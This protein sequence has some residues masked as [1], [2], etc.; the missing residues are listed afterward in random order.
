MPRVGF[1]HEKSDIKI[2]ILYILKRLPSTVDENDL[3]AL[4][5]CD[6]GIDYFDYI[7]CIE[8]LVKSE[9]IEK[10]YFGVVISPKGAKYIEYIETSLPI[11][12][13]NK[14]DVEIVP[15]A[16]KL[17]RMSLLSTKH[18]LTKD[19]VITTLSM[20]DGAGEL[21]SLNIAVPSEEKALQIEKKFRKDAEAIYYKILEVLMGENIE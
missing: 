3:W 13:R 16:K 4:V 7:E 19:S 17:E 9:S 20:N 10:D 1:I 8:D 21:L 15:I 2:L 12:V 18:E 5:Q 11:S 6:D 14:V